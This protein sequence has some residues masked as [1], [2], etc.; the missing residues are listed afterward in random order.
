MGGSV[1]VLMSVRALLDGGGK[2]VTSLSAYRNVKMEENVWDPILVT[3]LLDGKG[4][5]ATHPSVS[6][7]VCMVADVCF[8][9]SV[10]VAQDTLE[11]HVGKRYKLSLDKWDLV[12]NVATINNIHITLASEKVI[13]SDFLALLYMTSM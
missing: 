11:I 8:Q 6:R 13:L 1:W 4:C 5:S 2:G 12:P 10:F 7:D 9:T 3:V